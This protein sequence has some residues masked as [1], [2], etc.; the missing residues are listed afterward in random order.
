LT[1]RRKL[2]SELNLKGFAQVELNYCHHHDDLRPGL[3][4]NR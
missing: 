4:A 3:I 2:L 1:V